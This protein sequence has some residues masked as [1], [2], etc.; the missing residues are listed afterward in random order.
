MDRHEFH[1]RVI[2]AFGSLNY[3]F[4]KP[5]ELYPDEKWRGG[6]AG[7]RGLCDFIG[8]KKSM[9]VPIL[10]FVYAD[11]LTEEESIGKCKL[12]QSKLHSFKSFTGN[13]GWQSLPITADVFFVYEHSEKAFHF[14]KSV[15]EHCKHYGISIAPKWVLPWGIDVSAKSVWGYKGLPLF[16]L[17]PTNIEAALFS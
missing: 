2:S 6:I 7:L 12:I 3:I 17:K 9:S 11:D 4:S 14:R 10:L 5:E 15:Q 8:V 13:L 16:K 1:K